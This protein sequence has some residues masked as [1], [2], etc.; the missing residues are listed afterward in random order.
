M[1]YQ[2]LDSEKIDGVDI[3]NLSLNGLLDVNEDYILE[4]T[5]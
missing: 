4:M 2:F 3:I 5:L 1:I